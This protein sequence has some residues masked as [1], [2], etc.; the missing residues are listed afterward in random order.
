MPHVR[1][2]GIKKEKLC[3]MAD[4][5]AEIVHIRSKASRDYIKV[6]YV[7][8]EQITLKNTQNE[9]PMVDVYWMPRPQEICDEIAEGI[10]SYL[11]GK[12]FDFVQV[13]FTEFS[14]N[15]FYENGVH[16]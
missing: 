14:G 4:D 5:L 12:G 15:L 11:Q 8:N 1:V 9:Y 3:S 6:I 16:Y 7:P 10:T 13:T 2:S